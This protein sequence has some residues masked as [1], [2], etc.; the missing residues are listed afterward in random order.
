MCLCRG[1]VANA[2]KHVVHD[3]G[4]TCIVRRGAFG[5]V[6]LPTPT[7]HRGGNILVVV[8]LLV[9]APLTLCGK[10]ASNALLVATD[11]NVALGLVGFLGVETIV[12]DRIGQ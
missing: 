12:L 3:T 11:I 8:V 2:Y 6:G 4:H 1:H 5:I 7:V 10:G 9:E